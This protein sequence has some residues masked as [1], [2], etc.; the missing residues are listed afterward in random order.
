MNLT[1]IRNMGIEIII[2]ITHNTCKNKPYK[3]RKKNQPSN[4][5]KVPWKGGAARRIHK[6][7][8]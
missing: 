2:I 7:K 4:G 6:G 8:R 1:L 5:G 3:K